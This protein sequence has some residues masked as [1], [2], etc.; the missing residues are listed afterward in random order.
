M[1]PQESSKCRSSRRN[2]GS[3]LQRPRNGSSLPRCHGRWATRR[4]YRPMSRTAQRKCLPDIKLRRVDVAVEPPWW[5]HSGASRPQTR[6][7]RDSPLSVKVSPSI[8]LLTRASTMGASSARAIPPS[9]RSKPIPIVTA[10]EIPL[11]CRRRSLRLRKCLYMLPLLLGQPARI[12]E[13]A[14]QDGVKRVPKIARNRCPTLA[15]YA[16]DQNWDETGVDADTAEAREIRSNSVTAREWELALP[17]EIS[18]AVRIEITRAF[19]AQQVMLL[20]RLG[21]FLSKCASGWNWRGT[22][23]PKRGRKVTT[24]SAPGWLHSAPS[25]GGRRRK[26]TKKKSSSIGHLLLGVNLWWIE[27]TM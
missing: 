17:S 8:N 2:T 20:V 1:L 21:L 25:Q 27:Q 5:F 24:M 10:R 14:A 9:S 7:R 13:M 26:L 12:C 18:D 11:R 15:K 4:P 22:P 16:L 19:A 6:I 23:G 3:I